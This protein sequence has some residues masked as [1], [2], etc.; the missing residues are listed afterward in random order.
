MLATTHRDLGRRWAWLVIGCVLLGLGSA[1]MVASHLGLAP[2]DVLHQGIARHTGLAIGTVGIFVGG[3][4]LLAWVPVRQRVGIG[5]AVNVVIVGLSVNAGLAAIPVPAHTAIAARGAYLLTGI[6]VMGFGTA[7][8]ISAALSAGPRDGLMTGLC[9]RTG[10]SV[11]SVRSVMEVTV[12]V[13][14]IALSG[15]AG[16]GTVLFALAIG[17][18]IQ[19]SL[20][21]VASPVPPVP[22][23]MAVAPPP[24]P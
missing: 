18:I 16:V 20:A 17:P 15:T 21:L 14:G 8:Y 6:L 5:T 11:R 10:R 9:R 7:L 3:V 2:W 23:G 24:G 1:L 19:A 4:V 22:P 13:L 12:L